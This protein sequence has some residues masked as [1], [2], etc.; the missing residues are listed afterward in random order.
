MGFIRFVI[1]RRGG[2][3]CIK[4]EYMC[5]MKEYYIYDA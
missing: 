1:W 4:E 3:E 2:E 5:C